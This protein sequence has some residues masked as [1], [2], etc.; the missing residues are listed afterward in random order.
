MQA[1][2]TAQHGSVDRGAALRLLEDEAG[3]K[4]A[5]IRNIQRQEGKYRDAVKALSE[6]RVADG[7]RQLDKLGWIREVPDD[8]REQVLAAAYIEAVGEGKTALVVSPSHAEGERI[9]FAIREQLRDRK[10]L[11]KDARP[12]AQLVPTNF[13]VGQKRDALSYLPGDVIIYHQNAKGHRKGDQLIAGRDVVPFDQAERFTVYRLSTLELATGDRIRITKNGTTPEGSHRLNNGDLF[14]VKSFT[15]SGD[16]VVDGGRIIP[17]E[18]GHLASGFVTTSHSSQGRTVQCVIIGQSADSFPASSQ[19]Q[20]YVSVSRGKKQALVF[21]DSKEDLLRAV[22]RSDE[23]LSA[24]ELVQGDAAIRHHVI[25]ERLA[26]QE[27]QAAELAH[28][29]RSDTARELV[30]ER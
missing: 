7:Y 16:I 24:T 3:L 4:P 26:E 8:E 13:T 9:A 27:R 10:L 18:Y 20:F 17:K 29:T 5:E 6:G 30:H 14:T 12:F 22:S 2:D 21:T 1:G 28:M 15:P 23:R 19:E 25:R 11:G